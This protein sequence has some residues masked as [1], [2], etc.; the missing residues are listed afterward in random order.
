MGIVVKLHEL[1]MDVI[2]LGL[3]S[4]GLAIIQPPPQTSLHEGCS[5]TKRDYRNQPTEMI[6]YFLQ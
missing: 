4:T 2:S 3:I 6:L 1:E 5:A